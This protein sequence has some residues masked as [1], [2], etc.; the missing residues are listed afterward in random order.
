[1]RLFV[2]DYLQKRKL[3]IF[4]SKVISDLKIGAL[5]DLHI[6]RLVGLEKLNPLLFQLEKEKLDYI[7]FLG[8]LMDRPI[9]TNDITKKRELLQLLKDAA[10][11]APT[12]VI[13][14]NHDYIT[15]SEHCTFFDYNL[16][17]WNEVSRIKNL[18]LLN[19]MLY[20][21]DKILFMGYMQKFE[22]YFSLTKKRISREDSEEFY[23][24]FVKH[25]SLYENLP[26]SLPKIGLI[27]SLEF[28][29]AAKNRNLLKDFDLLIGGHDHDGCIPFGFGNFNRGIISPRKQLFPK[30]VRGTV[31]LD[32]GTKTIISGGIV[33]IQDT[34]PKI[35]HPLNHLCPMQMDII[36]LTNNPN[37]QS[38]SKQLIYT[39]K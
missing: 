34:A 30:N 18:F 36:T 3:K 13:L 31:T 7:V 12:M 6:S 9:L 39:K 16:E 14:G 24:D 15:E 32:T 5:G 33:K 10:N 35:L 26:E 27:H 11:I 8:D 19:D 25:T 1:M 23:K 17:F 20:Y 28:T 21:D 4:N 37:E 2:D 29:D 38:I 22:Y